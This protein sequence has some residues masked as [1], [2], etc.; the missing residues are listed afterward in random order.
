V[1]SD[2]AL[3]GG[4]QPFS[5]PPAP[6]ASANAVQKQQRAITA[7]LRSLVPAAAA[8][9]LAA[10]LLEAG[11]VRVP[12]AEAEGPAADTPNR[13]SAMGEPPSQ[14]HAWQTCMVMLQ[15]E[16]PSLPGLL[17]A[18]AVANLA[19]AESPVAAQSMAW[20]RLLLQHATIA[21]SSM[22][23][24]CNRLSNGSSSRGQNDP[25]F[26]WQPTQAQVLQIVATCIAAQQGFEAAQSAPG[27]KQPAAVLLDA[28]HVLLQHVDGQIPCSAA[29]AATPALQVNRPNSKTAPALCAQSSDKAKI[30]VGSI[31]SSPLF[32]MCRTPSN[33]RPN[34]SA[35]WQ[36]VSEGR[37]LPHDA[38]TDRRTYPSTAEHACLKAFSQRA[39]IAQ[40]ASRA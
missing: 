11:F 24:P 20:V 10:P 27:G 23:A 30:V 2:P 34:C 32:A 39:L 7:E 25:A 26:A 29:R 8:A 22:D 14:L 31:W 33:S 4:I 40:A 15:Q 38:G 9:L 16:Y 3:A 35:Q 13:G 5:S 12:M 6:H 19:A 17:L 18:G 21:D 28:A 36:H 1:S 37:L